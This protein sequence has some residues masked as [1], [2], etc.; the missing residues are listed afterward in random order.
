[1]LINTSQLAGGIDFV[2]KIAGARKAAAH[3]VIAA[4]G[5]HR[6]WRCRVAKRH[7]AE[8]RHQQSHSK[9]QPRFSEERWQMKSHGRTLP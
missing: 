3:D 7:Q 8:N 9:R 2:D 4:V 1:M 6:R 5:V